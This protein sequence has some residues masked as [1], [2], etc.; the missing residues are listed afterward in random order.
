M[1]HGN[2]YPPERAQ[3]ALERFFTEANLTAFRELSLRLV[4]RKVEGQIEGGHSGRA[5]PAR[6]R[7]RGRAA[8]WEPCVAP[9]RRAA[10]PPSLGPWHAALV[11]GRDRDAR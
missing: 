5:D 2:V 9:G 6:D 8:G 7:S 4:A 1:K 3:V 10:P 11:G